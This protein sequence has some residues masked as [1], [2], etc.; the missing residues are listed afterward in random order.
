MQ[1]YGDYF[2]PKTLSKVTSEGAVA[3]PS[4][5]PHIKLSD[6]RWVDLL[7]VPPDIITDEYP[8]TV[9]EYQADGRLAPHLYTQA[10]VERV[11]ELK[12]GDPGLLTHGLPWSKIAQQR[13][14]AAGTIETREE[15]K[16][17]K[18]DGNSLQTETEVK[19]ATDPKI[20][21]AV[22]GEITKIT[23]EKCSDQNFEP[24]RQ[25]F[26]FTFRDGRV[27][28]TVAVVTNCSLG[29]RTNTTFFLPIKVTER[30][31]EGELFELNV[32]RKFCTTSFRF[33]DT[34]NFLFK[35]KQK[36]T[37]VNFQLG[38]DIFKVPGI[39]LPA[40]GSLVPKEGDPAFKDNKPLQQP[41]AGGKMVGVKFDF[42]LVRQYVKVSINEF[43][44]I[45]AEQPRAECFEL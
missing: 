13:R 30:T 42:G 35:E 45:L 22:K 34:R 14:A 32:P 39:S 3:S 15:K 23:L 21:E 33:E 16:E 20:I 29:F 28:N 2:S 4:A 18:T 5:I 37:K 36:S 6:N 1:I 40:N 7:Y 31:P 38:V 11:A 44:R 25:A 9:I 24:V 17:E 41:D 27:V 10:E 12:T 26:P 43:R 19:L 8:L